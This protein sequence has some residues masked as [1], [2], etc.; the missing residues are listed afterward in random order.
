M[1]PSASSSSSFRAKLEVR[2]TSTETIKPSSPTTP[3]HDATFKLS[4][5]DNYAPPLYMPCVFYYPQRSSESESSGDRRI[6]ILKSSLA[7]ALTRFY[8]LAGRLGEADSIPAVHCNDA[9]V[10]FSVA[11]V[12]HGG[13]LAAFLGTAPE[14]D[15]LAQFLP[16]PADQLSTAAAIQCAPQTAVRATVF[17]CG[18]VVVGTC[19]FHKIMD[20]R[21]FFDFMLLWSAVARAGGGGGGW[22]YAHNRAATELFPARPGDANPTTFDFGS[23][24]GETRVTR[25]FVFDEEAISSLKAISR[26]EHVP[27]PTRFEAVGGFTWKCAMNAAATARASAGG[28]PVTIHSVAV[29]Q[30]YF[31]NIN[32]FNKVILRNVILTAVMATDLR[33]RMKEP[34]PDYS[35]GN[36]V[37]LSPVWH[38]YSQNLSE[39]LVLQ[40][41]ATELRRSKGATDDEFME[42]I[43]GGHGREEFMRNGETMWKA[44]MAGFHAET[45]SSSC[46]KTMV[47]GISSIV[48]IRLYD[49]DFGWGKPGWVSMTTY[50]NQAPNSVLLM[51]SPKGHGMEAWVTLGEQEIAMLQRDDSDLLAYAK[52]NPAL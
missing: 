42:K 39:A 41:L 30:T 12:V 28:E 25:R 49:V 11:K 26:S 29:Y 32:G 31:L 24:Q 2:I 37:W 50:A 51:P 46:S 6:D 4:L 17:P 27:N 52:R 20:A 35:I 23:E 45:E 5:M 18:G 40:Q 8:P 1:T 19:S 7:E 34:L 47:V 44:L 48:G 38:N 15:S 9:G 22:G 14:P 16:F 33:G 10:P 3:R 43:E 13:T 21:T 36:V